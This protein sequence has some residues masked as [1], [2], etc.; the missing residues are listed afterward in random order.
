MTYNELL[1]RDENEVLDH[2]VYRDH[3]LGYIFRVGSQILMGVHAGS[4]I[5]GG[6]DWRNGP[7]LITEGELRFLRSA[8]EADFVT[9]RV[10]ST[11]HLN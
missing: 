1:T 3:T 4:V 8:T 7:V 11:G 5:R 6:F 2:V 9:Y 10:D